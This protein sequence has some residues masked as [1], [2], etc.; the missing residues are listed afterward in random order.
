MKA[1][2]SLS[3]YDRSAVATEGRRSPKIMNFDDT[4][5]KICRM[6][7]DFGIRDVSMVQLLRESGYAQYREQITE[8]RIREY[9]DTH[10]EN[11][12]EWQRYS[13]DQRCSPS[14]FFRDKA[15]GHVAKSGKVEL[16]Q[17]YP[18]EADACAA[19]VKRMMEQFTE[20]GRTTDG[21][22]RR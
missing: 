21:T 14:W 13:D 18:T 12:A 9:V 19:Y 17:E 3:V 6:P 10:R 4:I 7:R 1:E 2:Q 5:A 11:I 20:N 15:I 22:V 8:D 16:D